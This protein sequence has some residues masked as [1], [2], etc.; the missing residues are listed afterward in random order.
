VP[1]VPKVPEVRLFEP[2]GDSRHSRHPRHSLGT[3]GTPSVIA[4]TFVRLL[5][6]ANDQAARGAHDC[7]RETGI[8]SG[9]EISEINMLR[10]K[11]RP[12]NLLTAWALRWRSRR[13]RHRRVSR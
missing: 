12:S 9:I 8:H 5:S 1:K 13:V 4:N 2:S 6:K 11:A 3:P 10:V 7:T